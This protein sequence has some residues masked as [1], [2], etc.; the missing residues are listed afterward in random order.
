MTPGQPPG[1]RE[2]PAA[3]FRTGAI[4]GARRSVY[5]PTA[6]P[7]VS[8]MHYTM[9]NGSARKKAESLKVAR[10][11]QTVA[12]AELKDAEVEL[13]SL[14]EN[15]FPLWDENQGGAPDHLWEP[16][17]ETLRGTDALVVVTPEWNGMT[18]PG[19]RNFFHFCNAELVAHKPA[20]IISVSAGINGAYPVAELR[21]ASYKNNRL[22][23]IPEHLIVRNVGDVLNGPDPDNKSDIY[24][25][26]RLAYTLRILEAYAGAL[27]TVRDSGVIDL[28][29]YPN[30]M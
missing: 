16:V 5:N 8:G 13:I 30:G 9:I 6:F 28:E 29:T 23:Y 24:L 2:I 15:P 22:C 12:K 19:L 17:A 26:G 1:K 21:M 7:H 3:D 14:S 11:A 18:P 4:S 25:R 10:F 27:K 20:A